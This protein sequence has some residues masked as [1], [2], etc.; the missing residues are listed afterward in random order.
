[1]WSA[2]SELNTVET[3]LKLK[4]TKSVFPGGAL[5]ALLSPLSA[6]EAESGLGGRGGSEPNEFD[7]WWV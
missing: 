7:I 2:K 1:M 6:E 4:A 3:G 5:R